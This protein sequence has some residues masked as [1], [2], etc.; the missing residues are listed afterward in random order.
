MIKVF[1]FLEFV[2]RCPL[3]F[4]PPIYLS[5]DFSAE[6]PVFVRPIPLVSKEGEEEKEEMRE[7]NQIGKKLLQYSSK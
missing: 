3:A 7:E 4:M 6:G 2:A 5:E 1:V